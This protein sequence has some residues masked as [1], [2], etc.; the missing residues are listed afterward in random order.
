M[1]YTSDYI[2]G[3]GTFSF[4]AFMGFLMGFILIGNANVFYGTICSRWAL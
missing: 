4:E 3:N 1:G 2:T